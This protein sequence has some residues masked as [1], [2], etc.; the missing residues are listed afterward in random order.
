[1]AAGN[2]CRW[3]TKMPDK[4]Y[5]FKRRQSQ[6]WYVRLQN[7]EINGHVYKSFEKSLGTPDIDLARIRADKLIYEHRIRLFTKKQS[8]NGRYE[9]R[10]KYDINKI[11]KLLDGSTII[12]DEKDAKLFDRNGTFVKSEPNEK[13]VVYQ[14]T[15]EN[16]NERKLL[17]R[18][19]G[20]TGQ[21][22]KTPND[23]ITSWVKENN[24]SARI[25]KDGRRTYEQFI[26]F[27]KGKDIS[28]CNRT[29]VKLFANYL[30]DNG[31]KSA[32]VAKKLSFLRAACNIAVDDN[33]MK[34]NPFVRIPLRKDDSLQRL[35]LSAADMIKARQNLGILTEH[36]QL[37]WVWLASTG[38]RL[39]EAFQITEEF[40]ENSIR[41]IIVGTK[42]K[43]SRRRKPIPQ[44]VIDFGQ[45]P[46]TSS[47]FD[48]RPAAASHRLLGFLRRLEISYDNEAKTGNKSKVVHS[49][50]HRAKDRLR[51]SRCPLELQYELLGHEVLTV[52]R[53]YGNGSP[54]EILKE[55]I[56]QVSY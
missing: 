3:D 24:V 49:L 26:S 35:P 54:L 40:E 8:N 1:M 6:N 21:S 46:I 20:E 28:D 31:M 44:A 53:G 29:E 10:L 13:I 32:T 34:S 41:Y 36:D 51:A 43:S 17:N 19:M 30:S 25:A 5:L 55:A 2:L 7:V 33:K 4:K 52:A 56:D 9:H 18:F 37:L 47:V 48:G 50:R 22:V 42:T 27:I 12:A 11:T 23:I 15:P 45:G 16:D 38:M 14:A 39:S